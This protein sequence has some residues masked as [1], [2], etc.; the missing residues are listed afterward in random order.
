MTLDEYVLESVDRQIALFRKLYD[1]ANACDRS[2]ILRY[3][4]MISNFGVFS[5]QLCRYVAVEDDVLQAVYQRSRPK[6][7]EDVSSHRRSGQVQG[8]RTKLGEATIRAVNAK[9]A[10]TLILFGYEP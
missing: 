9:L 8:F 5:D 7:T 10:D 6:Q 4:D 3:E 1:L 2:T